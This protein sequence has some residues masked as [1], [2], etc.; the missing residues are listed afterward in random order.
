[1][2]EYLIPDELL[3]REEIREVLAKS[4]NNLRSAL[5][6]LAPTGEISHFKLMEISTAINIDFS[7]YAQ[8]YII[9]QLFM[10]SPGGLTK[11]LYDKL[12]EE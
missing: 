3:V 11:L 8:N 4:G 5:T 1:M 9:S 6:S 7:E 10:K 2:G 12:F